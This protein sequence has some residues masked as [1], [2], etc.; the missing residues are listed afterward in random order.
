MAKV[1]FLGTNGWYDTPAGNTICT[2]IK[3]RDYNIVLDAGNGLAKLCR[4]ADADK[5]VYLFVSHFHLDHVEGLHTLCLNRFPKGVHFILQPGGAAYLHTLMAQ[6][7]TAPLHAMGFP[8]TVTEHENGAADLPFRASF[9]PL[10][11]EPLSYGI[12]LEADGATIAHC[13]DTG[14]CE[15]AVALGRDAD[16]LILECTL[17]GGNV[18]DSHLCPETCARIAREAGARRL[19]LTHFEA[20][21]HPDRESREESGAIVRAAGVDAVVCR[22]GMEIGL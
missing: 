7:Y 16:L 5:P 18:R 12:R 17:R 19:A 15:N 10:R 20:L 2:L 1:I 13:L 4:V 11:H 21:S 3:T 22:D 9:L 6:P 14:Y 8:V